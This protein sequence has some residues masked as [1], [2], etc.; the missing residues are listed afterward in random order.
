M[1]QTYPLQNYSSINPQPQYFMH[2]PP[3]FSNFRQVLNVPP[4]YQQPI[5]QYSQIPNQQHY[6]YQNINPNYSGGFYGQQGN[7]VNSRHS[8]P[9]FNQFSNQNPNNYSQNTQQ[10]LS[11]NNQAINNMNKGGLYAYSN[12]NNQSHFDQGQYQQQYVNQQKGQGPINNNFYKKGG[13]Y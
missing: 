5:I 9:N 12:Q 10:Y 3:Q 2:L 7:N 1:P 11:Y 6:A 8:Q 4:Q 13:F